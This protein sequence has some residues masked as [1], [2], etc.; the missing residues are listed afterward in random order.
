[1]NEISVD[2]KIK[3]VVLGFDPK[4]NLAGICKKFG[5]TM[6]QYREWRDLFLEGARQ[7][8]SKPQHGRDTGEIR[9]DLEKTRLQ[10]RKFLEAGA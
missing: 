2:E 4:A 9:R 10:L 7:A 8:L 3:I 5:I 6:N 1:M